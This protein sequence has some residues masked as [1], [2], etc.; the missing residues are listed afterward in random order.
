LF[1]EAGLRAG[2]QLE[3]A[4]AQAHHAL[5]VLR[6][7]TNDPLVLFDGK[8]GEYPALALAAGRDR[9]TVHVGEHQ[10]IER[11]A[12]LAVTLLQGVSS[13]ERMD[14]T[15]QKATELG[16]AVIQPLQ[17][18]K[19]LVRLSAERAESRLKHWQRVA[20]AACE[21]CGRNRVP[22]IRPVAH[23]AE[24]CAGLRDGALRLHL[25]PRAPARLRECVGPGAGAIAL[26]AGPEAG[27]S[28]AEESLLERAGFHAVALGPRI[29]RA[30]TAAL[31]ALGAL[32]ALAGDF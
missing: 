2:A 14:F 6:L 21:Q 22:E 20:V 10:A 5:R 28:P 29:L 30:E 31:A 24:A 12:P 26:A 19:S 1:V 4:G 7:K 13:A 9:L 17:A 23:L 8:G 25:S 32:H 3:L 18:E 15:V 16:V 27:F 11:E